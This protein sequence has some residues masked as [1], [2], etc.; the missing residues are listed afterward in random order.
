MAGRKRKAPPRL[1]N[2]ANLAETTRFLA[3]SENQGW[4]L[5]D[6]QAGPLGPSGWSVRV[7]G[8]TAAPNAFRQPERGP[9]RGQH[10]CTGKRRP[11]RD[12]VSWS[13][14]TPVRDR[15]SRGGWVLLQEGWATQGSGRPGANH[16]ATG[17]QGRTARGDGR[18]PGATVPAVGWSG[19]AHTAWNRG[20]SGT[21]AT[22]GLGRS[23]QG[24]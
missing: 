1:L 14:E 5:D 4:V 19:G 12:A 21:R 15:D 17:S 23:R 13:T 11:P 7:T 2:S 8:K 3:S 20:D 6:W 10:Q 18:H 24:R 9:M 16:A 22:R